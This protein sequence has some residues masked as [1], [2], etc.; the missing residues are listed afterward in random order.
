MKPCYH[1]NHDDQEHGEEFPRLL[2]T[3]AKNCEA[4]LIMICDKNF[5]ERIDVILSAAKDL[6][7]GFFIAL[8]MTASPDPPDGISCVLEHL[9]CRKYLLPDISSYVT[10]WLPIRE[11]Q[12]GLVTFR[13]KRVND[14]KS[15]VGHFNVRTDFSHVRGM[16]QRKKRWWCSL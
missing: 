6:V 12:V 8:R 9:F 15:I 14:E 11:K 13:G 5:S 3:T 2:H 16:R 10:I 1:D 4:A 7:S